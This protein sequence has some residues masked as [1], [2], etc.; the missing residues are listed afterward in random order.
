VSEDATTRTV[1]PHESVPLVGARLT[2]QE[3]DGLEAWLR[4]GQ[5]PDEQLLE[6]AM[7]KVP[8]QLAFDR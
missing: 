4:W 7:Q 3:R 6:R 1:S 2:Q 5:L 8:V